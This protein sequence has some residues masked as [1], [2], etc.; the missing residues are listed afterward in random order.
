ME[1]LLESEGG[2][3]RR[4]IKHSAESLLHVRQAMQSYPQLLADRAATAVAA[5]QILRGNFLALTAG[6]VH[7]LRPHLAGLLF[8]AFELPAEPE[9]NAG[10]VARF[11]AQDGFQERLGYA[12]SSLGAEAIAAIRRRCVVQ[13]GDQLAR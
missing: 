3:Q 13:G 11:R 6:R 1:G 10:H 8:E 12:Q 2:P 9:I 7:D 5:G 4:R